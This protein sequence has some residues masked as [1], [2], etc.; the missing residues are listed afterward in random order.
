MEHWSLGA[1]RTFRE[2]LESKQYLGKVQ[3]EIARSSNV[4]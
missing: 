4:I 2:I 3:T 1:K